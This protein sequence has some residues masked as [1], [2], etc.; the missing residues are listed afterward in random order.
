M[1]MNTKS[2]TAKK[3]QAASH[4]ITM[5]KVALL[6]FAANDNCEPTIET[7]ILAEVD[8]GFVVEHK[9]AFGR[10]KHLTLKISRH[11]AD[12]VSEERGLHF[13]G[14]RVQVVHFETEEPLYETKKVVLKNW[15]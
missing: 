13:T 1:S 4:T 5:D 11:V 6:N 2:A 12:L 14:R 15:F 10:C 9:R 7:M 8:S 3:L